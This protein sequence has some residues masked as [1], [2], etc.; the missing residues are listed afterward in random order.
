MHANPLASQVSSVDLKSCADAWMVSAILCP[1]FLIFFLFLQVSWSWIS[2]IPNQ[3]MNM[4]IYGIHKSQVLIDVSSLIK[5]KYL[6]LT[7][8]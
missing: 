3:E 8:R 2:A 7:D 4:L 5:S 1:N 6:S